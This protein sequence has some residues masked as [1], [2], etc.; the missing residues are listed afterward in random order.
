VVLVDAHELTK[1]YRRGQ[2]EISALREVSLQIEAG[3]FVFVVGPSGCG[4]STLLHLLGGMDRP[5]R[6]QL[7]VNGF[8]LDTASEDQ[9]TRFR[10][11]NI[12]FVFQ[13]YNLISSLN[14]IDNVTLPLL[15]RG[16][17][18]KKARRLA[19]D[20]LDKVGLTSRKRHK[21]A[22]LSGGEQQ[23]VAIARA[24]AGSPNLVMADEPTGDLD[25]ANAEAIM[26][27]MLGLN[28]SLGTTFVVATHN[29]ALTRIGNCVYELHNGALRQR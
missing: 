28:R 24:M 18:S 7:S 4:K 21:P 11:E 12:G 1:I 19:G 22:E 14:A 29:E 16:E 20:W 27:L 9:L 10:R 23:R 6:G 25:S 17:N 5:T 26:Q 3:S 15:A 2:E 13:F 8:S